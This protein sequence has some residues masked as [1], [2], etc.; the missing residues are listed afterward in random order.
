LAAGCGDDDDE[1]SDTGTEST[2][3]THAEFVEEGNAICKAGNAELEQ[4][5]PEGPPG[6]PEFDTFVTDTLVPNVQG[7]I[8]DLRDLGIPEEDD[9]L[10]GTLD[11]AELITQDLAEDPS[12][13]SEGG[14]PFASINDELT[15]AGL[16]ECAS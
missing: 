15:A 4:S 2:E 8:Q 10:N 5:G 9:S 3:L 6:S 16:T 1:S 7:Q 14:D 12:L 13:I 11:E